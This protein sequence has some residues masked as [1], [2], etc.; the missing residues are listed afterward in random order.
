MFF[1]QIDS[2][3]LGNNSVEVGDGLLGA[4][5]DG[6]GATLVFCLVAVGDVVGAGKVVRGKGGEVEDVVMPF[7]CTNTTRRLV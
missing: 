7:F 3:S 2:T 1:R 5:G 6:G 4:P